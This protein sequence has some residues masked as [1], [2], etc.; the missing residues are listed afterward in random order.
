[1]TTEG[2]PEGGL[3]PEGEGGCSVKPTWRAAVALDGKAG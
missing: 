3:D 1:M 2:F